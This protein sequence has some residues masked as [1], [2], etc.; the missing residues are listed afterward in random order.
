MHAHEWYCMRSKRNLIMIPCLR[1]VSIVLRL[2]ETWTV[3]LGMPDSIHD[4]HPAV[5]AICIVRPR[6]CPVFLQGARKTASCSAYSFES[7]QDVDE[8][9]LKTKASSLKTLCLR[10][11][12]PGDSGL[13]ALQKI[14]SLIAT[15]TSLR[16]LSLSGQHQDVILPRCALYALRSQHIQI[17]GQQR[18][19]TPFA[20][21]WN[22]D[23]HNITS[24]S[25]WRLSNSC[26]CL[27]AV[28]LASSYTVTEAD[29]AKHAC[30]KHQLER[31]VMSNQSSFSTL[32]CCQ[33][34]VAVLAS[35]W[36]LCMLMSL[37]CG[38]EEPVY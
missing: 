29:Y 10:Q 1:S 18:H 12:S 30:L 16:V 20:V 26:S 32:E 21:K 28:R 35:N 33:S 37:C 4:H 13:G 9:N 11:C 24:L 34:A 14:M 36:V 27:L 38:N 6:S 2:L 17:V 15:S 7:V 22:N 3:T 8:L 5:A 23:C 19:F 25:R 31:C